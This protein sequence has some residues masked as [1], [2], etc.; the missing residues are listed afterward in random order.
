MHLTSMHPHEGERGRLCPPEA[1]IA[2]HELMQIHL[3]VTEGMGVGGW[4]SMCVV[5]SAVRGIQLVS[6][7]Y[8]DK[9]GFDRMRREVMESTLNG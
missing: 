3:F 1:I 9:V 8:C 4:M 6:T 5:G 2:I 7:I